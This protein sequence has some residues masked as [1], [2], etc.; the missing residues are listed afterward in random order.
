MLAPALLLAWSL[1]RGAPRL[2]WVAL[3]TVLAGLAALSFWQASLWHDDGTLFA[4]NLQRVNGESHVSFNNL[5]YALERRAMAAPTAEERVALL[6]T[7]AEHFDRARQLRPEMDE[8]WQ[9]LAYAQRLLGKLPEAEA[10]FRQFL[11]QRPKSPTGHYNLGTLLAQQHRTAE[12]IAEFRAAI[13]LRPDYA[14]AWL[15][16]AT[17]LAVERDLTGAS[18]AF[19]RA[20]AAGR[21]SRAVQIKGHLGLAELCLALGDRTGA[22]QAARVAAQLAPQEPA[23]QALVRRLQ[24]DDAAPAGAG[25]PQP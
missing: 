14:N 20:L 19:Q 6:Q 11:A 9:R 4:H 16:L 18:E 21:N 23:V 3:G 2:A 22:I 17:Q 5:G 1:S 10:T 15:E 24:A 25:Q 12:A 13:A 7:A 8:A